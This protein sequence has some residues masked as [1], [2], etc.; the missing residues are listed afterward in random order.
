MNKSTD[1]LSSMSR[2]SSRSSLKNSKQSSKIST[3]RNKHKFG[4]NLVK[5][6][7]FEIESRNVHQMTLDHVMNFQQ[8]FTLDV[9][10]PLPKQK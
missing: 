2:R 10:K 8:L 9:K 6:Q 5:P 4:T 7:R 1:S 3:S